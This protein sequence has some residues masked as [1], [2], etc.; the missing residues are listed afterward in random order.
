MRRPRTPTSQWGLEPQPGLA[1]LR[2]AQGKTDTAAAAI[3]R[4]VGETPDRLLRAKLLPAHVEIMLAVGD[5]QAAR[6]AAKE[7]AGIADRYD[8]PALHAVADHAQGA[9]LLD[10]GD[11]RA[12]LVALPGRMAD[13]ARAGGAV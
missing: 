6:D 9:I 10:D 3:R 5:V 13:L 1:L 11:A 2:L 8:T 12:A 4:V 7:L